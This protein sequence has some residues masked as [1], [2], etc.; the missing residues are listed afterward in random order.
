MRTCVQ[1]PRAHEKGSSAQLSCS[2]GKADTGRP[3]GASQS[4]WILELQVQWV[5]LS[6]KIRWLIEAIQLWHFHPWPSIYRHVH[7]CIHI[8]THRHAQKVSVRCIYLS[9]CSGRKVRVMKQCISTQR[10]GSQDW[11]EIHQGHHVFCLLLWLPWVS[12]WL[13][14][15]LY[16]VHNPCVQS[17]GLKREELSQHH[18][19]PIEYVS[20]FRSYCGGGGVHITPPKDHHGVLWKDSVE[21]RLESLQCV[22]GSSSS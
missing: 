2:W 18:S 14:L 12:S 19:L 11:G 9:Q 17:V 5:I 3:S 10:L 4:F 8:T 22:P 6:P 21:A 7:I 13:T 16:L 20:Q 15:S 1:M